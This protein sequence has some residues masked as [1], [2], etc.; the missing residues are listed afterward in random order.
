[1]GWVTVFQALPSSWS[2]RGFPVDPPSANEATKQK[3]LHLLRVL[4]LVTVIAFFLGR[5]NTAGQVIDGSALQYSSPH[6]YKMLTKSSIANV[7]HHYQ[8]KS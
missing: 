8:K 2:G 3:V 7:T 6:T 4:C 1:M 5:V